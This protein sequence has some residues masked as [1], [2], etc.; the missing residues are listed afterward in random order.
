MF[1]GHTHTLMQPKFYKKRKKRKPHVAGLQAWWSNAVVAS[2]LL[3]TTGSVVILSEFESSESRQCT[4]KQVGYA[5]EWIKSCPKG[6]DDDGEPSTAEIFFP[7]TVISAPSFP[8]HLL[9]NSQKV[10]TA[11]VFISLLGAGGVAG[12]L[13]ADSD[14]FQWRKIHCLLPYLWAQQ[15]T[16]IHHQ[17]SR[18]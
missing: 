14:E 2:S 4:L 17:N 13:M 5:V 9:S 6:G 11:T 7:P 8:L 15:A 16:A 12:G 3:E 10:R 18:L 1:W